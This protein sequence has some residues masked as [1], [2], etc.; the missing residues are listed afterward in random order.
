VSLRLTRRLLDEEY[1]ELK[2]VEQTLGYL[3]SDLAAANARA[4]ER[5]QAHIGDS[6]LP[7]N[8]WSLLPTT[9]LARSSIKDT[10]EV[11]HAVFTRLEYI[12]SHERREQSDSGKRPSATRFRTFD[13]IVRLA[14]RASADEIKLRD[15]KQALSVE[16]QRVFSDKRSAL[17]TL[18]KQ[19]FG[20]ATSTT[21]LLVPAHLSIAV[22][23][24]VQAKDKAEA[25]LH[26]ALESLR[27][28]KRALSMDPS[29]R[30]QQDT[31]KERL[32][33]ALTQC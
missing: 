21:P 12:T 13:E 7:V 5:L 30:T 6:S 14:E 18:R 4:Q 20:D 19:L 1:A 22:R 26:E 16:W 10:D 27:V 23:E 17:D 29:V 11:A 8:P 28:K 15:D 25:E 33:S 24:G 3:F 2:H 31:G 9:Q 32:R